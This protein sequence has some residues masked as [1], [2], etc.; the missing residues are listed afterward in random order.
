MFELLL[1]LLEQCEGVANVMGD[2]HQPLLD[3]PADVFLAVGKAVEAR[4]LVGHGGAEERLQV[5]VV[6][7]RRSGGGEIG[8]DFPELVTSFGK[9]LETIIQSS[10]LQR[11]QL[12]QLLTDAGAVGGGGFDFIHGDIHGGGDDFR[13]GF[14]PQIRQYGG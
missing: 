7:R 14:A 6:L 11:S 1:Y 5:N 9:Q 4:G 3:Y 8:E 13:D 10:L 12:R 2:L